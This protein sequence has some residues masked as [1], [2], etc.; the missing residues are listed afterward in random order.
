MHEVSNEQLI[1]DYQ[2]FTEII[3]EEPDAQFIE[4]HTSYLYD[5][6]TELDKRLTNEHL[7]K[8]VDDFDYEFS[9]LTEDEFKPRLEAIIINLRLSLPGK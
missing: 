8:E 2:S 3:F 6:V 1:S 9:E 7:K 4:G 5:V